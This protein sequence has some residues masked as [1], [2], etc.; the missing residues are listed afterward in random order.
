MKHLVAL[1]AIAFMVYF[2]L[3]Y[4]PEQTKDAL[5]RFRS[6]H[7]FKVMALILSIW[8]FFMVQATFGSGKIF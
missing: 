3:F 6:T 4:L 5:R 7:L 1:T 8:L 2:G